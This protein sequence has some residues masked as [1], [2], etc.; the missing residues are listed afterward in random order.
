MLFHWQENKKVHLGGNEDK[1][2]LHVISWET[3][4]KPKHVGEIGIR[5]SKQTNAAFWEE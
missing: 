2:G 5:P 1:E 4:Q 3:L